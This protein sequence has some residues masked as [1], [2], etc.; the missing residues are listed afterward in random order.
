M[1]LR[2]EVKRNDDDEDDN[3]DTVD[4]AVFAADLV[5]LNKKERMVGCWCL[6]YYLY[7][8]NSGGFGCF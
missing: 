2:L 7:G 5:E 4:V 8:E 1:A 6:F 3:E